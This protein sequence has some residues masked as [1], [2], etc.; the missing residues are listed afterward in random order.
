MVLLSKVEVGRQA[1]RPYFLLTGSR[2]LATHTEEISGSSEN[3]YFRSLEN[4]SIG[5]RCL[6]LPNFKVLCVVQVYAFL[7]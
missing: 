4:V 1:A 7:L 2:G 6:F 5:P 3:F